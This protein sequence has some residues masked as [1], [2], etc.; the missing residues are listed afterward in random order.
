MPPRLSRQPGQPGQSHHTVKL[1]NPVTSKKVEVSS[2]RT[3]N[4]LKL[5]ENDKL[6]SKMNSPELFEEIKKVCKEKTGLQDN[7]GLKHPT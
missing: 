7:R 5:I 2:R 3:Q 4:S 6:V 1:D